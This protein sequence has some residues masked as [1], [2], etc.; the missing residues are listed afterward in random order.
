MRAQ[1]EK[2]Y[3]AYNIVFQE[4]KFSLTDVQ[5]TLIQIILNFN[6]FFVAY[7]VLSLDPNSLSITG[8]NFLNFFSLLANRN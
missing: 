6:F 8:N 4:E 1:F 7:L 2:I 5:L 3:N